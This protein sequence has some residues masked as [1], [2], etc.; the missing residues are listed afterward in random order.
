MLTSFSPSPQL[1]NNSKQMAIHTLVTSTFDSATNTL[2][3]GGFSLPKRLFSQE[4]ITIHSIEGHKTTYYK[5]A[6][7]TLDF[8]FNTNF[9]YLCFQDPRDAKRF[10]ILTLDGPSQGTFTVAWGNSRRILSKKTASTPLHD[11]FVGPG[12]VLYLARPQKTAGLMHHLLNFDNIHVP[13]VTAIPCRHLVGSSEKNCFV[14]IFRSSH[15]YNIAQAVVSLAEGTKWH[16]IQH[17]TLDVRSTFEF[18]CVITSSVHMCIGCQEPHCHDKMKIYLLTNSLRE[19]TLIRENVCR[20]TNEE[21]VEAA[22]RAI[23][24]WL[25][26]PSPPLSSRPPSKF[27][28]YRAIARRSNDGDMSNATSSLVAYFKSFSSE[29]TLPSL[30]MPE[31]ATV[32]VLAEFSASVYSTWPDHLIM[33]V[34]DAGLQSSVDGYGLRKQG[35]RAFFLEVKAEDSVLDIANNLHETFWGG[36]APNGIRQLRQRGG[37]IGMLVQWRGTEMELLLAMPYKTKAVAPVL[38]TRHDSSIFKL[39]TRHS[40]DQLKCVSLNL[41]DKGTTLTLV[42]FQQSSAEDRRFLTRM[43]VRTLVEPKSISRGNRALDAAP[44]GSIVE[45]TVEAGK[46][47]EALE[48]VEAEEAV[49][50]EKEG[51]KRQAEVL[52]MPPKRNRSLSYHMNDQVITDQDLID[53]INQMAD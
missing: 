16:S 51:H 38:A 29:A 50:H 9:G 49:C 8:F 47:L 31:K 32:N 23:K 5:S 46:A 22:N 11:I 4:C 52:E 39:Y 35:V 24:K 18:E 1:H 7:E 40:L 25:I 44:R 28:H 37:A 20:E 33:S 48:A 12:M 2:H 45:A 19:P 43:S 17:G 13:V 53:A 34:A 10:F 30:S 14:H 3:P 42:R 36:Y 6:R 27:L 15:S 21:P 41:H 26:T